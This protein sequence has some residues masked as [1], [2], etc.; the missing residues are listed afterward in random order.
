MIRNLPRALAR[1]FAMAILIGW[2]VPAFAKPVIVFAASST[3]SAVDELLERFEVKTGEPAVASY[4]S[5]SVL[6]RQI[7]R[8]APADLFLSANQHWMQYLKDNAH[9]RTNSEVQVTTNRLSLVA[10]RGANVPTDLLP[11]RVG[12][13]LVAAL[14]QSERLAM[15]DPAHV[16]LGQYAVVALRNLNVWDELKSRAV[17]ATNARL[18]IAL[19]ARSE[20]MLGIVYKSDVTAQ[21]NVLELA[22]VDAK[23][24]PPIQYPLAITTQSSHNAATRLQQFLISPAGQVIFTKHGFGG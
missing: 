4:A 19:V 9:V 18:A 7:A 17:P 16:P 12:M 6:A 14:G 2:W 5:S 21:A 8:G 10:S 20:A 3:K 23:W 24:H 22:V 1:W 13:P 15:G 11:V